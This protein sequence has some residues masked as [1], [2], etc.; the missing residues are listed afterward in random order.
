MVDNNQVREDRLIM[1]IAEALA[2]YFNE[3]VS[4][5]AISQACSMVTECGPLT[6]QDRNALTMRQI[7]EI[8][9]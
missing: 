3:N 6:G 7:H 9:D 5:A 1:G 8:R 2:R 4:L